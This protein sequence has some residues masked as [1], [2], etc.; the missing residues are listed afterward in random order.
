MGFSLPCSLSQPSDGDKVE[1]N[2][3]PPGTL[4]G[5]GAVD[6]CA[7]AVTGV[8]VASPFTEIRAFR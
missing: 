7:F 1:F 2:V 8:I 4:A 6:L 3:N 5:L